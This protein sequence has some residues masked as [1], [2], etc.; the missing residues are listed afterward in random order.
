MNEKVVAVIG[1]IKNKFDSLIKLFQEKEEIPDYVQSYADSEFQGNV[2]SLIAWTGQVGFDACVASLSGKPGITDPQRLCGWLKA[3]SGQHQEGEENM[4]FITFVAAIAAM[5]GLEEGATP[6]AVLE[7][8]KAK[9]MPEEPPTEPPTEPAEGEMSETVKTEF[10]SMQSKIKS[11]ETQNAQFVREKRLNKY[12]KVVEGLTS[13]AT[14]PNQ[15]EQWADLEESAGEKV[16]EDI[17]KQFQA[18]NT[19]AEAS[20]ILVPKG[21]SLPGSEEEDE[22][23]KEVKE[24][25][26]ENKLTFNQAMTRLAD[27]KP[28]EF[29][30]YHIR[31]LSK[32]Q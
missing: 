7:A 20:G 15:A 16:V 11:L 26:S 2:D 12:T 28:A 4:D 23:E 14:E 22:F 17:V 6:E 18:A 19:A 10:A 31:V 25:A 13:I 3:R 8:L 21:T 29:Q 5:L 32:N 1:D 30:A 24:Y 9:L 27:T